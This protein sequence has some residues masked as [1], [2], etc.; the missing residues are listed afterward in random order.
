GLPVCSGHLGLRILGRR[1][2]QAERNSK[3]P[4][5]VLELETGDPQ[6]LGRLP[7]VDLLFEVIA[8]DSDLWKVLR[9]SGVS[10]GGV[11]G[12]GSQET[13]VESIQENDP[14]L[15]ST[16]DDRKLTVLDQVQDLSGPFGELGW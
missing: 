9:L 12:E 10:A 7:E 8:D 16:D 11:N 13:I 14:F 4:E 6:Q 1:D 15:P 2:S 3:P 5:A